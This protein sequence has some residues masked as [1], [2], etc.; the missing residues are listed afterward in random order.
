VIPREALAKLELILA[1]A[2]VLAPVAVAR[3][4]EGVGHL[5]SEFAWH[6]NELDEPD[7]RRFRHG[8]CSAA[9]NPSPIGF[10]DLRLAVEDEPESAT[11]G[12]Q[13]QWLK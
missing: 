6:V 13:S 4:E 5:P 9:N 2:T 3:K 12:N 11:D 1:A 10:H 7:H 8:E